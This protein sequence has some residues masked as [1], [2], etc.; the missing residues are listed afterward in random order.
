MA[1]PYFYFHILNFLLKF[2]SIILV[3]LE[4]LITQLD[5]YVDFYVS[6]SEYKVSISVIFVSFIFR[7]GPNICCKI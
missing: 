4:S 6:F 5:K 1:T 7:H 3:K 2:T